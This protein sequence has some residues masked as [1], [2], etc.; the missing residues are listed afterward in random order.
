MLGRRAEAPQ[1]PLRRYV[2]ACRLVHPLD[3]EGV[4]LLTVAELSDEESEE[5]FEAFD[6]AKGGPLPLPLV[7]EEWKVEMQFVKDRDIYEYRPTSEC[8]AKTGRPPI[9]TKWVDMNKGD[10]DEPFVRSRLVAMEC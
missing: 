2:L 7:R 5:V 3:T 4:A 9:G 6:D 1:S 8:L 10:D